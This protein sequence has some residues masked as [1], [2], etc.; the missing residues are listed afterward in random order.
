[1][2]RAGGEGEQGGQHSVVTLLLMSGEGCEICLWFGQHMGRGRK[3]WSYDSRG[4]ME[5]GSIATSHKC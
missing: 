5:D 1:M 2:E 3:D 4:S